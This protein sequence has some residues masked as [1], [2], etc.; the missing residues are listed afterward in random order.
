MNGVLKSWA[1]PKEPPVEV[2]IKRLAVQ[3]EDHPLDY[4]NFEGRIPEGHYGAGTVKI[5]DR[6]TVEIEKADEDKIEFVLRGRKMKG[7]YALIRFRRAG[8]K[9]WLFFRRN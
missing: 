9:N 1:V 8:E 5:W 7:A 3:T 2:G 4:A 6:G